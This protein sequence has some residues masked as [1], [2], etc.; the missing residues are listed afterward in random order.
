VTVDGAAPGTSARAIRTILFDTG[1]GAFTFSS[2]VF[3]FSNPGAV[4]M[5]SGTANSQTINTPIFVSSTNSSTLALTN[6]DTTSGVKLIVAGSLTGQ[7]SPGNTSIVTL[8]GTGNGSIDGIASD[9]TGGGKLSVTMSGAG[10]WTLGNANAYSAKTTLT[11]GIVSAGN[12]SAFGTSTLSLNAGTLQGATASRT[13]SNV[14]TLD[15]NSTIS[16]AQ[17][18][19]LS[20]NFTNNAGSFTLTNNLVTGKL[21]TLSGNVFLSSASGTARTLTIA[22]TGNTTVSGNIANFNGGAGTASSVTMNGSGVLTQSGANTY[23]GK[24]IISSGTLSVASLNKVSGGGAS[25]NLGAPTTA[26]NGTIDFGATTT[27]GQLT[28]SGTGEVTDRVINLAGTTGGG[29]IDQAGTGLLKFTSTNTATGAGSKTLT[30]QG[31]T[32]GT[33]EIGGPVV[34]GSGTTFVT[35]AGTGSWTLSGASTYTGATTI[36]AGTLALTG[37]GS[38]ATSPSI[39]LAGGS[40]FSVSGLTTSLTLAPSQA[41]KATGTTTTGTIATSATRGLTTGAN[42]PLQFTAF[43]AINAPLTLSGAGTMT[44]QGGNP[45]T[46]KITNN[47]NPLPIGDFVLISKGPDGGSVGG[48]VPTSLTID[49]TG[50]Q[51]ASGATASLQISGQQLVLHVA[52]NSPTAVKLTSF[53]ATRSGNDVWLRWQT[54]YEVRNLGY[55]I[56]REQNGQRTLITPSLVAGSALLAGR[57]TELTAGLSYSWQDQISEAGGQRSDGNSGVTYWLEDVDLDGTKTLH[58]PIAVAESRGQKSE[59]RSQGSEERSPVLGEVR[60]GNERGVFVDAW[61]AE[62]RGRQLEARSQ[63]VDGGRQK[64]ESS[65]LASLSVQQ[66]IAATPGVKLA[67]SRTGWFRVTQ[68][69][70]AAAG[71]DA[72]INPAQLQLFANAE[73]VPIKVSGNGTQFTSSDYVEFYGHGVSSSTDTAQTY[74]LIAGNSAGQRIPT[75]PNVN[76]LAPPSGPSGFGYTVERKERRIY[77]SG[78]LNGDAE[79][80]FGRIVSTTPVPQTVT[81]SQLDP[82]AGPAQLEVVLQGV[83]AGAHTVQVRFNSTDLG[84]IAFANTDHRVQILSVPAAALLNG[85]NTVQLTG[86]GGS[87][88][89]SLIDTLRLTYA[90]TFVAEN[91]ALYV[92][93]NSAGTT[94]VGGFTA[95]NVRAIDITDPANVQEL[96]T[97]VTQQP[98]SSYTAD[99]RVDGASATQPHNVLVFADAA[100]AHPDAITHNN[101]STWNVN[102]NSADYL[103]ITTDALAANLESLASLRRARG[104]QVNVVDVADLYDEFSF[105]LHTPQAIR[106]FL[107]LASTSWRRAPHFVLFAGDSSYDPKN[108]FGRGFNDQ[109]PSKLLDTTQTETASD[110]WLADFDGDGITDLAIGR[111]P[112]RTPADAGTMVNKIISFE[113]TPIDPSRGA[114]LVADRT[115]EAASTSLQ[116]ALPAGF[117]VQTINRS[118][119]DDTS[120]H[121]QI[122][123]GI[124]QGPRVTN[125]FGHGSNGVWT[126]AFLLSNQD[127]PALTNTNRLS[128]FTMMTCYNGY[129]QDALSESLSETLLKSPGGAVAVWASTSLTEPGGQSVIDE[130]FYRQMF[131]NQAKTLGDGVRVAKSATTDSDVRRTWTLFGDPAMYLVSL[132]PT[133]TNGSVGGTIT[134]GAG[135]PLAGTTIALSG[136]KTRTTITDSSGSYSFD[137]LETNGFYT[138]TPSR[139][140]YSFTPG[141]RSFSLLGSRTEAVFTGTLNANPINP[142]DTS[143]YFVRQ[144]YLDFLGR[145]PDED[146]FNFW[147]NQIRSCGNDARCVETKRINTSA[148]FFLSI[149][150]QQTGYLVY[151]TYKSAYGN[152][153]TAPV[154]I[155]LS[156]FQPDTKEIGN[157]VVVNKSGWE[158]VL[159]NNKQSFMSEFVQ[160]ARFSSAYPTSLTPSEF[161]DKLFANSGVTPTE[162]DRLSAINEFASASTSSDIAARARALRRVSENST[163][164]QIEFNRAFVLMQ[165]FGYLRRN[166]VDS[167]ESTLD[168]AGYDFWLNKLDR[169]N[170][171][172]TKAEMVRAF[173]VSGEY[174]QRFS[175]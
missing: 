157:G 87:G 68:T 82:T 17:N 101:P 1:A 12:D 28:Y 60:A 72:N 73:Q 83:T 168:Y 30:L 147:S 130:E 153:P 89:V 172:F 24:T 118:S 75:V 59:S 100:A 10:T 98:D 56:Y 171:D 112:A 132:T 152:M 63:K 109:V 47:G 2:G 4:T 64:A 142:L 116:N 154:P 52:P 170:G 84:T 41:L 32:L 139:V 5:N 20:N 79:N 62:G 19:S 34:N 102:T 33:G 148:A 117:P 76:P 14:V 78:L 151:R 161:V 92:G 81:A 43:N 51:I 126:S 145:E 15:A 65:T 11:S 61:P 129:F 135:K 136:A 138:V 70:L 37:S 29:A 35:K 169:F 57:Q 110:D 6:N 96:T 25:S 164:A 167:P 86:L 143:D 42:S 155:K 162:S 105:G 3:V 173:I 163:L 121:N 137:N 174:R 26:A 45:V 90:H 141:S 175:Q 119:S 58:G 104:M 50:D 54:G 85:D 115:F 23:S 39:E 140:N 36:I 48:T 122:V 107:Q 125:Y 71:L 144:H 120:I 40:T 131:G 134:D 80:F 77:F 124:N 97:V 46:V 21:L 88:D 9:G 8:S 159:E 67:V 95:T 99:L 53:N 114:L 160:R 66:G 22:G 94:R 103:I 74:Y 49:P 38:I 111:L 91:D 150:F 31:S 55:N 27:T 18:I 128:V 165:Y 113:N 149:E 166:P 44:L 146:G 108:Y 123:S 7:E 127:A 13:L 69:E 16:G 133:A 156:E 93:V 158:Q 106:D